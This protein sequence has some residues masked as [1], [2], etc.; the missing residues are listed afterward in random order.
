MEWER[1]TLLLPKDVP[2]QTQ[3]SEVVKSEAS[4]TQIQIPA[5]P[6]TSCV[7]LDKLLNFSLPQLLYLKNGNHN[8][9][10]LIGML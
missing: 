4:G 9:S 1:E 5:L 3:F 10:Y 7:T 2:Q 8:R 6:F